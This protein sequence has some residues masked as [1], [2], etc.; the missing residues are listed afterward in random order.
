MPSTVSAS[1]MVSCEDHWLQD[2]HGGGHLSLA[3][4]GHMILSR[5][6]LSWCLERFSCT[7]DEGFLD[8]PPEPGKGGLSLSMWREEAG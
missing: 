6:G 7:L 3:K 8:F 4:E 5:S 1:G 2:H